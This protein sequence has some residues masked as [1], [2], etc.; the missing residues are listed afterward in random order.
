MVNLWTVFHT[1]FT[2]VRFVCPNTKFH[3][4]TY[5]DSLDIFI[6]PKTEYRLYAAAMLLFYS[7]ERFHIFFERMLLLIISVLYITWR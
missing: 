7:P 4:L 1:E 3:M 2:L 5:R 6:K